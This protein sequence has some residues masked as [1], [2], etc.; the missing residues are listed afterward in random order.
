MVI[1]PAAL[2]TTL[3]CQKRLFKSKSIF[4]Y[5]TQTGDFTTKMNAKSPESELILASASPYRK[6][7]L[8]R[9]GLQFVCCAPQMVET[10]LSGE[11]AATLTQRLARGKANSISLQ[12]PS[13]IVIGCDQVAEF[14]GTLVGKP[15]NRDLAVEQLMHFSG[16]TV[17]FLSALCVLRLE[18]WFCEEVTVPTLVHFRDYSLAEAQRY[19]ELDMPLDCAGSFKSEAGGSV[20]LR[21]L[22]SEDPTA[23]IGLPLIAL[24][25]ILRKMGLAAP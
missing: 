4:D 22:E 8:Q 13:A 3:N 21:A 11:S 25:H 19:I 15:A 10:A 24:S 6:I 20:L 1:L 7:L 12:H 2:L 14:A 5:R 18:P 9:L 17:Q 23:L 16:N